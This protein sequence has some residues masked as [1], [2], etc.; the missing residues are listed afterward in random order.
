M[1]KLC[2]IFSLLIPF[3]PPAECG[4]LIPEELPSFLSLLYSIVPPV[5]VGKDSRFGAGFRVGPNADFQFLVELGPQTNTLPLGPGPSADVDDTLPGIRRHVS[6]S[7][8]SPSLASKRRPS[9]SRNWGFNYI[10]PKRQ[11]VFDQ[12]TNQNKSNNNNNNDKNTSLKNSLLTNNGR[13]KQSYLY[14][15]QQTNEETTNKYIINPTTKRIIRLPNSL[16]VYNNTQQIPLKNNYSMLTSTTNNINNPL[17]NNNSS[18]IIT[19]DNK[20]TTLVN[21]NSNNNNN[22]ALLN[23]NQILEDTLKNSTT[24]S[25]KKIEKKKNE[26]RRPRI[27]IRDWFL[28]WW[29]NLRKQGN[30][31][32]SLTT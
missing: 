18:K 19:K 32:R 5:R 27:V 8:I 15:Q 14:Q 21:S 25:N 12:T 10:Q 22:I 13:E 16:V 9:S 29:D 7:T 26:T 28:S 1:L 4:I 3:Y 11:K 6:T 17:E 24:T 20:Q 2:W 31:G 30:I 23:S